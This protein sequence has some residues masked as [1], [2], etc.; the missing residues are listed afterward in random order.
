MPERLSVPDVRTLR[1]LLA[2]T[3]VAL[4]A[5]VFAAPAAAT[6]SPASSAGTS[7]AGATALPTPSPRKPQA[8]THHVDINSASRQELM[9]LP[10]I[11][12]K[13]AAR[14]VANR[15]YLTKTELVT[16]GVLPM[17]PFLSLKHQVVAMPKR[18]PGS[19]PQRTASLASP[20]RAASAP[21]AP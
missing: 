2:T 8:V 21:N 13:E 6:T 11:G 17:G 18:K 19:T 10:G 4:P 7:S 9:T 16:K 12:P 15:P 5:A 3:I 1:L 20:A 14:I